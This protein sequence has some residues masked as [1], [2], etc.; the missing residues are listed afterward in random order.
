M[1]DRILFVRQLRYL[2]RRVLLIVLAT[3]AG[4]FLGY[5]A[6]TL[7]QRTYEAKARIVIGPAVAPLISNPNDVAPPQRLIQTYAELV[8]TDAI[9]DLVSD[10]TGIPSARLLQRSRRWRRSKACSSTS[11]RGTRTRTPRR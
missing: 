6:S 8:E 10:D 2:G 3:V 5:F 9:A 4:L 7:T 1:N 11:S